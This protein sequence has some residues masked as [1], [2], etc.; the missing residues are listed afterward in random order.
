MTIPALLDQGQII[1]T[2]KFKNQH[3]SSISNINVTTDFDSQAVY[4]FNVAD[5][6]SGN[7]LKLAMSDLGFYETDGNYDVQIQFT[8]GENTL[9]VANS[10]MDVKLL[11]QILLTIN[12]TSRYTI[13][14]P[15]AGVRIFEPLNAYAELYIDGALYSRKVFSDG[16][17]TFTSSPLWACGTHNASLIVYDSEFGVIL[18]SS[19]KTFEVL[20][21][22]DDVSINVPENVRENAVVNL[23]VNVAK[24]GNVTVRF[25]NNTNITQVLVP[26]TNNVDLGILPHGNRTVYVLYESEDGTSFFNDNLAFFVGDDG[27]WLNF[28]ETIVLNDQDTVKIDF[29]PGAKVQ[30]QYTLMTSSLK[31]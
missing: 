16:L 29:G 30:Y 3:T 18:N 31:T 7:N 24:A 10:T 19:E 20:V 5:I 2:I 22:S 6:G 26:G 21:K 28:P 12:D 1:V 27:R 14:L 15:F 25:E 17:I 8:A 9:D 23:T 4:V 11:E 13:E